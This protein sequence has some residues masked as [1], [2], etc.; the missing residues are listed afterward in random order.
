MWSRRP[1][2]RKPVATVVAFA[3]AIASVL[4]A[5]RVA[6]EDLAV[7][8]RGERV[9]SGDRD[10]RVAALLELTLLVAADRSHTS[11][12]VPVAVAAAR[13]ADPHVRAQ[14]L[15]TL[16]DITP[17]SDAKVQAIAERMLRGSLTDDA[18]VVRH[19]AAGGLQRLGLRLVDVRRT[20]LELAR[21]S[22]D[23]A[24]RVMALR[25]LSSMEGER[26]EARLVAREAFGDSDPSVRAVAVETLGSWLGEEPELADFVMRGLEDSAPGVRQAAS[27][28]LRQHANPGRELLPRLVGLLEHED[29]LVSTTA[30]AAMANMG[31]EAKSAAPELLRRQMRGSAEG[32]PQRNWLS[33][34]VS[35]LAR[36]APEGPEAV[37]AMRGLIAMVREGRPELRPVAAV[38]LSE[39]GAYAVDALPELRKAS[40]SGDERMRRAAAASVSRIESAKRGAGERMDATEP[41]QDQPMVRP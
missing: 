5:W 25:D 33:E 24:T 26:D 34:Y 20:L 11:A 15:T 13:D 3:A 41:A 28:M 16:S 32:E 8:E 21:V 35:A 38:L 1:W 37:A 10:E 4:W 17:R 31:A 36:V 14:A 12:A 39:F 7:A 29:E 27:R 18:A 2:M 40:G 9:R 30:A 23:L 22:D 6:I 19:A